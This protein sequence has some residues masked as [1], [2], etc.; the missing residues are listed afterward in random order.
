MNEFFESIVDLEKLPTNPSSIKHMIVTGKVKDL[1]KPMRDPFRKTQQAE[2]I[3]TMHGQSVFKRP[4]TVGN[5][6]NL[7]NRINQ[8]NKTVYNSRT[9]D[10]S[11]QKSVKHKARLNMSSP[12]FDHG[13]NK[14]NNQV[15]FSKNTKVVFKSVVAKTAQMNI[16]KYMTAKALKSDNR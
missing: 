14:Q 11:N 3:E 15:V 1:V 16:D 10:Y 6:R 13:T 9:K 2:D 8:R 7:S 5:F 4:N 12:R